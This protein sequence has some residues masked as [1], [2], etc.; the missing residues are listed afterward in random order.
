MNSSMLEFISF[1]LSYKILYVADIILSILQAGVVKFKKRKEIFPSQVLVYKKLIVPFI[2]N[3]VVYPY[4][5]TNEKKFLSKKLKR[6][7]F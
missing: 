3:P 5:D 6:N 2:S 1:I 7:T 4:R